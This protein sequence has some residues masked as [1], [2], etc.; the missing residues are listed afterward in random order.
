MRQLLHPSRAVT[1]GF[2]FTIVAGTLLLRLPLSQAKGEAAPW[3]T[4]FFTATSGVCVTGLVVVDTGT[5]WSSFGQ[6]V[7]LALFQIGGFGMMTAATLLGLMVNRSLPLRAK[8]ITQVETHS[9]RLGDIASVTRLVVVVTVVTELGTA[10][11][12]TVRLHSGYNLRW[13][14]AAWSGLFHSVSAFN[15]AGFSIHPDSLMRY[16][17]DALMLVPVMVAI[18]AGGIG[19]PVLYDLREKIRGARHLSLHTKLTLLATG[20][21]LL[22][23][24]MGLL[25]FE[26]ANPKTL[27]AMPIPEKILSAA[28]ASVSARTAGFNSMD[29]GVMSRDSWALH[30]FLMFVGGGSAGTAGGIKIGTI[31]ILALLVIAEIRGRIWVRA[32]LV[33]GK[34]FRAHPTGADRIRHCVAS[35]SLQPRSLGVI[36]REFLRRALVENHHERNAW[37]G[38]RIAPTRRDLASDFGCILRDDFAEGVALDGNLLPNLDLVVQLDQKLNESAMCRKDCMGAIADEDASVPPG[39]SHRAGNDSIALK[40]IHRAFHEQW[41][42]FGI[43]DAGGTNLR[44]DRRNPNIDE[45]VR[46]QR[47]VGGVV[48]YLT[49]GE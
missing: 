38:R 11:W 15:N 34:T 13:G 36:D 31:A 47:R 7:I 46:K 49:D 29:I 6:W 44:R 8:L 32:G 21:L 24:F 48:E 16:S 40:H 19:F 26:W 9:L 37:L 12:L 42:H 14:E 27:G 20:M 39:A 35:L 41:N 3:L 1:L 30:Y 10:L 28:F 33:S 4:A 17:A 5:Y 2:L 23:G 22:A 18:V 45:G 25:L 43:E